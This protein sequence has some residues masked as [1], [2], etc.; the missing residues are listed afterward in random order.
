LELEAGIY[1]HTRRILWNSVILPYVCVGK[2]SMYFRLEF[3]MMD[4]GPLAIYVFVTSPNYG[5]KS[6][7]VTILGVIWVFVL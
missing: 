3:H 2:V 5:Y 6:Y 4:M 1:V 7:P